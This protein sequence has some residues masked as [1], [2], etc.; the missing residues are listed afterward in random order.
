MSTPTASPQRNMIPYPDPL[1]ALS[2]AL[3][4]LVLSHVPL[5]SLLAA[6]QVS[7]P[8]RDLVRSHE[9]GIWRERARHAGVEKKHM[10]MME[11]M[12]R[13]MR[14]SVDEDGQLGA[15]SVDWRMLCKG[16]VQLDQNWK[17][18]QCRTRSISLRPNI[19]PWRFKLDAEA[20]TI[21]CT[22]PQAGGG[23]DVMDSRTM[24]PLFTI[25]GVRPYAH[26]EFGR[27][28]AA[29][30]ID[31]PG[32]ALE[33]W[34]TQLSV[35]RSA[36]TTS[37]P[38][39]SELSSSVMS[40]T[41]P[42][43]EPASSPLPR[44]HLG[45]YRRIEPPT[46]CHAFRIHV[47]Q[48]EKAVLATA[49]SSGVYLWYLEEGC[50]MESV[51]V[52]PEDQRLGVA[53]SLEGA[54]KVSVADKTEQYVELDDDYVFV[55]HPRTI[56]IYSRRTLAK[57]LS[58]PPSRSH[59]SSD[60][61]G[62][63]LSAVNFVLRKLDVKKAATPGFGDADVHAVEAECLPYALY[64]LLHPIYNA[65]HFTTT[66]LVVTSRP[67]RTQAHMLVL[68][69]YRQV[70]EGTQDV[71]ANTIVITLE[72][73]PEML[74]THGDRVVVCTVGYVR[75][76]HSIVSDVDGPQERHLLMFNSADLSPDAPNDTVN[77][78][79]LVALP[80]HR[81]AS[82]RASGLQID[83]NAVYLSEGLVTRE[84]GAT[85]SDSR[86]NEADV[87]AVVPG[88]VT[89]PTSGVRVWDFS[90]W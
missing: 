1:T 30:D 2:P 8:W 40:F 31:G 89:R 41:H 18:G 7:K 51:Q 56:N 55:C 22:H 42:A 83:R 45:F 67:S 58:F 77:M 73:D 33:I 78:L 54:H 28:F 87:A 49:G 26:L 62:G 43:F 6:E 36:R 68:K 52:A 23:L 46:E 14:T 72:S 82:L 29:F 34:R 17:T 21:L 53:V 32:F 10:R 76:H 90:V 60:G 5:A 13:A 75:S 71:A 86:L 15:G 61:R 66:D 25:S 44:G 57:V 69:D 37:P 74:T 47:D 85:V 24:R 12:E 48:S 50:R 39:F 88:D 19:P 84:G 11:Q 35:S 3:F 20:G 4:L 64:S 79:A 27:G 81:N 80:P 16:V 63:G 9:N 38:G 70:I 65:C 59:G